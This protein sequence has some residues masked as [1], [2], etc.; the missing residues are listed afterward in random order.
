MHFRFINLKFTLLLTGSR[1]T[2]NFR[3]IVLQVVSCVM[4]SSKGKTPFIQYN[5]QQVEDTTNILNFLNS[6][7]GKNLNSNLN[8]EE[9]KK[10]LS[11]QKSIEESLHWCLEYQRWNQD[12]NILDTFPLTNWFFRFIF[13]LMLNCKIRPELQQE[14]KVSNIT[15]NTKW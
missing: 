11:F 2:S 12:E 9:V 6:Q 3:F 14:L 10:A 13:K 1:S 15:A 8:G 4:S 5:G 7:L